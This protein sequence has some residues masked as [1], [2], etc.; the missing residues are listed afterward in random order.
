MCFE[1]MYER[2]FTNE[3]V[4]R[5]FEVAS[6]NN[7]SQN[8]KRM[9][10]LVEMNSHRETPAVVSDAQCYKNH[11]CSFQVEWYCLFPEFVICFVYLTCHRPE[12]VV[13]YIYCFR[14]VLE[15]WRS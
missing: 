7:T 9:V 5:R 14:Q 13:S 10:G 11:N 4:C 8:F 1:F 12:N 2:L 15:S 6:E 3:S